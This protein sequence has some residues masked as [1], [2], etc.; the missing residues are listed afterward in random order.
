MQAWDRHQ[1]NISLT[2][3]FLIA[4][5]SSIVIYR[6]YASSI[7][8]LFVPFLSAAFYYFNM[9]TYLDRKR[10]LRHPFPDAWRRILQEHVEYYRHLDH[11]EQRRFEQNVTFFLNENRIT[12]IETSIDDSVRLLVASSAVIL[13]FGRPEWEYRGLP[14]ILIYPDSFGEDY[15]IEGQPAQRTL[16]GIVVPQ[17][18]IVLSKPDLL[19]AFKRPGVAYHVGL[20]EFAHVLDYVDGHAE[21]IPGDL[22][23]GQIQQWNQMMQDELIRVRERQSILNPYAGKNKAELFAV[24]VE[25]FFQRPQDLKENHESLYIAL[26]RFL[27]QDPVDQ[28]RE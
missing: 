13:T 3:A 16:T 19:H 24:A 15:S 10:W 18:G 21:G 11:Q 1:S 28:S 12:G 22:H 6:I 25:Y 2:G 5:I 23:P 27:N 8:F 7:A 9:K 4:V 20:H 14:E 26:A 17:N